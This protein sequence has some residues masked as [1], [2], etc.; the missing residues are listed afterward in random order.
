MKFRCACGEII[1]DNTDSLSYKAYFIADQD[2]EDAFRPEEET[3]DEPEDR[4]LGWSRSAWQCRA[5]GS[6]YI[7][8]DNGLAH[9]F[10]PA[11]ADTPRNI[12]SSIHGERWKRPLRGSWRSDRTKSPPGQLWWGAGDDSGFEEFDEWAALERR[13]YTVFERL[14]GKGALR[15]AFLRHEDRYLHRWPSPPPGSA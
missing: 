4:L 3:S 5:C 13:Y 6:L 15:D 9:R 1:V 7:D 14:L 8:D 12:L 2:W 11:T 10:R